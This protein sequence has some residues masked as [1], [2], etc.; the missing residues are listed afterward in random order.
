[1]IKK[2][3]KQQFNL[4]EFLEKA[5]I[6]AIPI[7]IQGKEYIVLI[8]TG[9]DASYLDTAVLNEI[10]KLLLGHQ[11][12]VIGGTGIKC[13]GSLVYQV[14]FACGDREFREEF[15]ENDFS[16]IFKFIEESYGVKLCGILGTRFLMKYK[17]ILDFDKL[18]FYL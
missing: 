10:S 1:M 17:C 2:Q 14:E 5:E 12:E 6:P 18:V 3:K 8:D 7:Y 15:T 16:R 13:K 4:K 9:S 11:E